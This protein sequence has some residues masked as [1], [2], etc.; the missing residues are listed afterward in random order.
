VGILWLSGIDNKRADLIFPGSRTETASLKL[1]LGRVA[2]MPL[3]Q[4][5]KILLKQ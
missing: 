5:T 2:G 4:G 3:D 1:G